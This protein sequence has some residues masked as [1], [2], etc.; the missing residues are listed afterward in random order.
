M[1]ERR[2]PLKEKPL[3]NPGQS[4]DEQI[5][6]IEQDQVGYY[7]V[8]AIL[9]MILPIWAWL[10]YLLKN[11]SPPI[12]VTI[13]SAVLLIYFVYRIRN[14]R[15]KIALLKLGRDGERVVAET[16]D[17]LRK[18]GAVIFHDILGD[19]FNIDHTLLTRQGVYVIETKTWSKLPKSRVSYDGKVLL[20]DG[21][22]PDRDPLTQAAALADWLQ[23]E[24]QKSTGKYFFVRPVVVFPG[25]FVE[26][27]NTALSGP[28]WVLNPKALPTF[29]R[30]E[31][32]KMSEDDLRLAA[33][34][35]ARL[36]RT[37]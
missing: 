36:V 34:H 3:R 12:G 20:V 11:P 16:L 13:M 15:A 8:L 18:D 28:V 7:I 25:W 35:L 31:A 22:S 14:A 32:A 21:K 26:S 37:T 6:R 33:Y 2:S 23:K 10:D 1:T 30:H 29:V 9:V 5:N 19:G 17:E 24:L 4:L 27:T